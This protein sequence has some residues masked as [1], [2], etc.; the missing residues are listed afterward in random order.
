MARRPVP[1]Y[2]ERC[3]RVQNEMVLMSVKYGVKRIDGLHYEWKATQ[4]THWLEH[5]ID[6]RKESILE[7]NEWCVDHL[8]DNFTWYV[9]S[10]ECGVYFSDEQSAMAFKMR[11]G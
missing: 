10:V 7:V 4:I 9:N 8:D 5:T 6:E 1:A 11:W 2:A 3:V